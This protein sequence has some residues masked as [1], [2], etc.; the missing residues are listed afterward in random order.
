M[1]VYVFVHPPL[2]L[3]CL[4]G[5]GKCVFIRLPAHECVFLPARALDL[6]NMN[7]RFE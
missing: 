7:E 4:C 3:Y 5:D 1:G 6:Q 2:T